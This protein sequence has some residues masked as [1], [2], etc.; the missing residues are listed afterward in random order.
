MDDP[1]TITNPSPKQ[2]FM[3]SAQSVS[4]HR[5]MI[6]SRAFERG[7]DFALMEYTTQLELKVSN[8]NDAASTGLKIQGALEFLQTLRMLG[9]TPRLPAKVSL[10]DNLIRT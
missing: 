3:E 8:M 5:D 6:A 1:I 4:A 10:S 2:R 9:E 7:A